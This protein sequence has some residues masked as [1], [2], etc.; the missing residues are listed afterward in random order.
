MINKFRKMFISLITMTM[1]LSM[2]PIGSYA[3]ELSHEEKMV[4]TILK[5]S[6]TK[7]TSISSTNGLNGVQNVTFHGS[8]IT[9]G[10]F[11]DAGNSLGALLPFGSGLYLG[12][13]GTNS[14][15][16]DGIVDSDLE[17]VIENNGSTFYKTGTTLSSSSY[18]SFQTKAKGKSLN[19]N[20]VLVSEEFNQPANFN[21]TF[22]LFITNVSKAEREKDA[23]T[24]SELS[25]AKEANTVNIATF[26]GANNTKQTIN[27]QTLLTQASSATGTNYLQTK[28]EDGDGLV[29]YV[30]DSDY[31]K[32][33]TYGQTVKMQASYEKSEYEYKDGDILEIKFAIANC[34]DNVKTSYV[35][36]E[37]NSLGF[38]T[39]EVQ[40]N[41]GAKT[42]SNFA[43][44]TYQ[45]TQ[46]N[47]EKY[48]FTFD[49]EN[50]DNNFISF[51]GKDM[52]GK[53]YNFEGDTI[54]IAEYNVDSGEAST[55]PDTIQTI[56]INEVG[57]HPA[58]LDTN[59]IEVVND[60][61]S[62]TISFTGVAG[63]EYMVLPDYITFKNDTDYELLWSKNGKKCA[64]SSTEL[65]FDQYTTRLGN[66]KELDTSEKYV[67][68]SRT[69]AIVT[70]GVVTQPAS[71]YAASEFKLSLQ[72][73]ENVS[74]KNAS[75]IT[76]KGKLYA[77]TNVAYRLYSDSQWIQA[78]SETTQ[79]PVGEY[80]VRNQ[81]R[82]DD[83]TL[84]IGA[85]QTQ[86]I[87]SEAPELTST[88][89]TSNDGY[90][91][92]NGV[93][94]NMQ[95]KLADI[96]TWADVT[97][98]ATETNGLKFDAS[99]SEFKIKASNTIT[100]VQFRYKTTTNENGHENNN[101]TTFNVGV[102]SGLIRYNLE[103]IT[104]VYGI[105]NGTKVIWS[106]TEL[107]AWE[108]ER[109]HTTDV[110]IVTVD[111][112]TDR[113]KG[114]F[115]TYDEDSF[116]NDV[117][118][119]TWQIKYDISAYEGKYIGAK[120]VTLDS[121]DDE[122]MTVWLEKDGQKLYVDA[123]L[124]DNLLEN[125]KENESDNDYNITVSIG[126]ITKTIF[127]A[128]KLNII[129]NSDED[130]TS[131]DPKNTGDNNA[132]IIF[133]NDLLT[134]AQS[135]LLQYCKKPTSGNPSD[136]D[137]VDTT[138][139]ADG[140][141]KVDGGYTYLIRYKKT[142][143]S[144]G[145]LK[146]AASDPIEIYVKS[147]KTTDG[148]EV[149]KA[150]ANDTANPTKG[151]IKNLDKDTMELSKDDDS[152][153]VDHLVNIS[154]I[155]DGKLNELDSYT[156]YYV[157]WKAT[158]EATASAAVK[159]EI[160]CLV[161]NFA[162]TVKNTIKVKYSDENDSA[163]KVS[164]LLPYS[165][166]YSSTNNGQ[167]T[168]QPGM[169]YYESTVKITDT[170]TI[171]DW[172]KVTSKD[173]IQL[174]STTGYL[175]VR[176]R[177]FDH[178]GLLPTEEGY[179]VDTYASDVLELEIENSLSKVKAED[180]TYDQSETNTENTSGKLTNLKVGMVYRN[181]NNTSWTEVT[182]D[183]DINV[184]IGTY[185]IA[186][187][188]DALNSVNNYLSLT[189]KYAAPSV[190]TAAPLNGE[191]FGYVFNIA[192]GAYIQTKANY[193]EGKNQWMKV[194]SGSISGSVFHALKPGDYVICYASS[195]PTDKASEGIVQEFTINKAG[196]YTNMEKVTTYEKGVYL[197]SDSEIDDTY[198]A[199]GTKAT[200]KLPS[201]VS[202]VYYD[203]SNFPSGFDATGKYI[204][205]FNE[206]QYNSDSVKANYKDSEERPS[207][208]GSNTKTTVEASDIVVTVTNQDASDETTYT[209]LN[210]GSY[211]IGTDKYL[212]IG[213]AYASNIISEDVDIV[214]GAATYSVDVKSCV[215]KL[216]PTTPTYD[217]VEPTEEN[218]G[219]ITGLDSSMEYSSKSDFSSDVHSVTGTEV[220]VNSGT[221]Y[222]RYKT[223]DNYKEATSSEIAEVFVPY[224]TG[225]YAYSLNVTAPST[226]HVGKGYQAYV[227]SVTV[228]SRS[229]KNK[230]DVDK[231]ENITISQAQAQGLTFDKL[232]VSSNSITQNTTIT[233]NATKNGKKVASKS[234]TIACQGHNSVTDYGY[235]PTGASTG[236]TNGSHCSIC[237]YVHSY[238]QTIA[239]LPSAEGY[240]YSLGTNE[241]CRVITNNATSKTV[242]YKNKQIKSK[243]QT[244]NSTVVL[245]GETFTV[246]ALKRDCVHGTY[247]R[248]L[249]L[250]STITK[251]EYKAFTG[252]NKLTK[253][254]VKSTTL[255]VETG[256]FAG[257]KASAKKKLKVYVTKKMSK[258]KFNALKAKLV[259]EG[260]KA[261]NIRRM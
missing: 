179:I 15:T 176:Q 143:N 56:E 22:G 239:A 166:V 135:G 252:D 74:T 43:K 151:F 113:S 10:T 216:T 89:A 76:T 229:D 67:I 168:I 210:N 68:Y 228:K 37:A 34:A 102:Q 36:I 71:A 215:T 77:S 199:S 248:T 42:L 79:L 39:P 57:T 150:D 50:K 44:G 205:K 48:Y 117:T 83:N 249:T 46:K 55:D 29:D 139:D 132:A 191:E 121:N 224:Y 208:N 20:Y 163:P 26:T 65:T 118:S 120:T 214:I 222:V 40:V 38:D 54:T 30:P 194:A 92:V 134:M 11:T 148:L 61:T 149:V 114:Y 172:T 167:V 141:L 127:V 200:A 110:T 234:V 201:G 125:N 193:D 99:K 245:G 147:Y 100:S 225:A 52:N 253:I 128:G 196:I 133:K 154:S 165:R 86:I 187:K 1:V 185:D 137:Y 81:Y 246:V 90:G 13:N 211:S 75:E 250:A 32:N 159:L 261:S 31:T 126:G 260:L 66:V 7:D 109:A 4:Q 257:M 184:S 238:Q 107:S 212:N 130:I 115:Y 9:S 138:I 70:G 21:D 96:S 97:S 242:A 207:T 217:V 131:R 160:P 153:D 58:Q 78:E 240:T 198:L 241:E 12:S 202:Y 258:K 203:G 226:V 259:K 197:V 104:D 244:I 177:E 94:S 116:S 157:R 64:D 146:D 53:D 219:K 6:I 213:D 62:K 232:I 155:T 175:Y 111:A 181:H 122:F 152:F 227:S 85:N 124:I 233:F 88:P 174:A 247:V 209:L 14:D 192:P 140:E 5:S 145:T 47:D 221:W 123:T 170:T 72:L 189:V 243:Y 129:D 237:G 23:G 164:G 235:A 63:D 91:I 25:A 101:T 3:A 112:E 255:E 218:N 27:I 18:L 16:G 206:I 161:T 236:L 204:Y 173:D 136:S 142:L 178:T 105:S 119:N 251:W 51:S 60:N 19:F 169:E 24:Y 103:K 183:G 188:S 87:I 220:T 73:P 82:D 84:I 17:K 190:T 33:A 80:V 186:Y 98:V 144:D 45:V 8:D 156:Y 106:E 223:K 108:L 195:E 230:S 95:Y 171:T 231:S 158:D 93:K 28:N 182:V 35:F 2:S 254:N 162:S 180:A 49:D 41:Y 256:A 59:K 69:S